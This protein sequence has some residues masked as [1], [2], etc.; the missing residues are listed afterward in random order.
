MPCFVISSAASLTHQD[1][2]I[3]TTP[4]DSIVLLASVTNISCDLIVL[5]YLAS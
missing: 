4:C 1:P 2:F 5:V 3:R